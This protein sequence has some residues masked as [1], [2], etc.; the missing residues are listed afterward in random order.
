M[1]W[2]WS[3]YVPNN[4]ANLYS[5]NAAPL[6]Y[7]DSYNLATAGWPRLK[8]EQVHSPSGL[9]EIHDVETTDSAGLY[10]GAGLAY[11]MI[12]FQTNCYFPHGTNSSFVAAYM[13]GHAAVEPRNIV[14]YYV[15]DNLPF[16]N[17]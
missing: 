14:M 8:R 13:D 16:N 2:E 3:K 17:K 11:W 9:I 12:G 4:A 6:T 10:Y 1:P 15:Y 5:Y 7:N